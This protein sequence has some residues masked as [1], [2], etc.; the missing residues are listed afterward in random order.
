ML[1]KYY[2]LIDSINKSIIRNATDEFDSC[3][4][5][6][7]DN[8]VNTTQENIHGQNLFR[9]SIGHLKT[10]DNADKCEEYIRST[11]T[12]ERLILIVSGRLGRILTPRIHQLRQVSSIYVYCLDKIM[13]EQWAKAYTKV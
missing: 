9:A 1:K 7:L 6:W 8:S 10:F 3:S 4:V 11:P 5:L 2:E 13:N 12:D